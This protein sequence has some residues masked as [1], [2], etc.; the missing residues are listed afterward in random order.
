MRGFTLVELCVVLALASLLAAAAWPSYQSQL[1]RGRRAD[2][3][4][5]LQR[6]QLAQESYRA[7]HG[8]YAAQLQVLNGAAATV[9]MQGLYDIELSG[10]GDRY[11]AS[12]H[13]RAG[14]A[15]AADRDCAPLR[16][17]VRDGV[18]EFA[19][20]ARCWNR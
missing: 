5:A 11:E 13:A 17:Q 3:V 20:S 16:L 10:G 19:P 15:A 9:S 7:N 6:V 8:L 18:A 4:Q 1:Q 14:T 12:A 2:A